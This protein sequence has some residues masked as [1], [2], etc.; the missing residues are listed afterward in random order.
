MKVKYVKVLPHDEHPNLKGVYRVTGE[1]E[2][3]YYLEVHECTVCIP[4][5]YAKAVTMNEDSDE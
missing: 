2:D 5:I 1:S 3:R 4:K